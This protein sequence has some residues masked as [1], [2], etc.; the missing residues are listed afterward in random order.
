MM[1]ALLPRDR[2]LKFYCLLIMAAIIERLLA[3]TWYKLAELLLLRLGT[4]SVR[5]RVSYAKKCRAI[6]LSGRPKC[7]VCGSKSVLYK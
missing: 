1:Q 7:D 6:K 3:N 5:N 4:L 2:A